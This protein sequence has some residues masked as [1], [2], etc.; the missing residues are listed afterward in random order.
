MTVDLFC[1]WAE[2]DLI[3]IVGPTPA[4]PSLPLSQRRA[5]FGVDPILGAEVVKA[6]P[7][8]GS[9]SRRLPPLDGDHW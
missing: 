5:G 2:E 6:E 8:S 9:P 7:P 4:K 1:I 3:S